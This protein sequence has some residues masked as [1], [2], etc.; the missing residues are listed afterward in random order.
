MAWLATPGQALDRTSELFQKLDGRFR[1][2]DGC[3]ESFCIGPLPSGR[4]VTRFADELVEYS[5]MTKYGTSPGQNSKREERWCD[6]HSA[7]YRAKGMAWPVDFT[8][9]NTPIVVFIYKKMTARQ[10]EILWLCNSIYPF[11][12]AIRSTWSSWT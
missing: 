10:A 12:Q 6:E 7:A 3:I 11:L 5:E 8:R 9:L 4:F 2:C 1:W